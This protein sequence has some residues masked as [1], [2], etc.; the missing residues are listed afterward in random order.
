M[1]IPHRFATIRNADRILVLGDGKII[2]ANT[3]TSLMYPYIRN[4]EEHHRVR[5]FA[6]AKIT[7]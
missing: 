5:T 7:S 6:A 2:M 4:Q 3:Y 1:T